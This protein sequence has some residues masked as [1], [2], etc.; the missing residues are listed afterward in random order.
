[1]DRVGI[2]S[3]HLLATRYELVR[4]PGLGSCVKGMAGVGNTFT[5]PIEEDKVIPIFTGLHGLKK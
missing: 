2:W 1:M 4:K 5:N 3:H